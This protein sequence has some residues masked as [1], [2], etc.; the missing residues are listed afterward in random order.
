[1]RSYTPLSRN[2]VGS[3]RPVTGFHGLWSLLPH[4]PAQL[5]T[6]A[7]KCTWLQHAQLLI[8]ENSGSRKLRPTEA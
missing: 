7:L 5:P 3:V 2:H 4:M 8:V 6:H 1:M